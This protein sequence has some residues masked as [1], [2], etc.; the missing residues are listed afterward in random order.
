MSVRRT[1]HMDNGIAELLWR[2][3]KNLN[4]SVLFSEPRLCAE[5]LAGR[6]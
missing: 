4:L 5:D 6:V 1:R 3:K 2:S